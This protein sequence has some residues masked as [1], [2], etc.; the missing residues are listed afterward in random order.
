MNLIAEII[1]P[2]FTG[3]SSLTTFIQEREKTEKA[4]LLIEYVEKFSL[5]YL[6]SFFRENARVAALQ[7]VIVI[8]CINT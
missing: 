7:S 4:V 2:R 6:Y 5:T 8:L 3:Q 1:E